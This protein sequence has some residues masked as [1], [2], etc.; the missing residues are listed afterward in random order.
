MNK[1]YQLRMPEALH[2]VLQEK[3]P[4]HVRGTLESIYTDG[5]VQV[6]GEEAAMPKGKPS[7]VS[8]LIPESLRDILR[9]ILEGAGAAHLRNTL[10]NVYLDG[11]D[12]A[13][14]PKQ[15][16]ADGTPWR[17][18]DAVSRN[19]VKWAAKKTVEKLSDKRSTTES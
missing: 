1:T 16:N 5:V 6:D 18:A 10:I 13:N 2:A 3:G 17:H 9:P 8:P 14:A 19:N 12:P 7:L 15:V 4:D 11:K